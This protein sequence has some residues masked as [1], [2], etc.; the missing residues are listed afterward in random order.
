MIV[1]TCVSS[2]GST[3]LKTALPPSRPD[4]LKPPFATSG[5]HPDLA[6]RTRAFAAY[7]PVEAAR[8]PPLGNAAVAGAACMSA[9]VRK[10]RRAAPR[11]DC[12]PCGKPLR[13][14]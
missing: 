4:A 13:S 9:G 2:L 14:L 5:R 8:S 6:A 7:Q 10:S 11:A 12:T 3:I 1:P